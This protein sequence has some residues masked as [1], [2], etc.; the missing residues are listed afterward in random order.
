ML[1]TKNAFVLG[2]KVIE[3]HFTHNKKLKG[4]DHYH[5]MDLRDLKNLR[6]ETKNLLPILGISKKKPV[7]IEINSRK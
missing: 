4:N 1:V 3:K 2:A 6:K 5:S 7:K